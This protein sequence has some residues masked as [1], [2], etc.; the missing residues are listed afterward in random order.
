MRPVLTSFIALAL[1]ASARDAGAQNA[2]AARVSS[3]S[4]EQEVLAAMAALNAATLAGDSAALQQLYAD[5]YVFVNYRGG[6][7]NKAHQIELLR[8][9]EMKF[10][11]R[12][13]SEV[14]V[15]TFG[16]SM[17][18]VVYRRSQKATVRGAERPGDVRVTNAWVKRSGRWQ[19]VSGQV[20][21]IQMP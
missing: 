16:D 7:D 20:T 14:N 11:T 15:R 9:G 2:N 13:A 12:T 5:D 8:T 1:L 17:A 4:A 3:A 18:I 10:A 19:L 6:V 21:P